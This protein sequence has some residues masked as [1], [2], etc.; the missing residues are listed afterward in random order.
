VDQAA[1]SFTPSL[2]GTYLIT[3]SATDKDGGVGMVSRQVAMTF[4]V[5]VCYVG[6][7]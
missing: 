1:F 2:A 5:C 4:G 6:M 3:L 7:K